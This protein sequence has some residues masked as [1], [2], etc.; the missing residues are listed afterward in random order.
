MDPLAAVLGVVPTA[1]AGLLAGRR[2][3]T[4]CWCRRTLSEMS[5]L[6][7]HLQLTLLRG[8]LGVWKERCRAVEDWWRSPAAL[9]AVRV[10]LAMLDGALARGRKSRCGGRGRPALLRVTYGNEGPEA[11]EKGVGLGLAARRSTS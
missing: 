6:E 9:P 2:L 11:P 7:E 4:G 5:A 8:A 3:P 10:R 1:L